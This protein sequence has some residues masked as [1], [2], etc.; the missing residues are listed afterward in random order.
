MYNNHK[1][2]NLFTNSVHALITTKHYVENVEGNLSLITNTRNNA[3]SFI[4]IAFSR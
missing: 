2:Q 1:S 4:N 3:H